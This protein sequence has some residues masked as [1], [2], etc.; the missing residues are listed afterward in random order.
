MDLKFD[1]VRIGKTRENYN[2]EIILKKNVDLLRKN[3]LDL[4]KEE[5]CSQKNNKEDITMIIPAR[6]HNIK[7]RL[8]DIKDYHIRKLL[9][10]NF[11][12]SIYKGN[13]DTIQDN[14]NNPVF[15]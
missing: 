2:S 15:R 6:G 13:L 11:P 9:R 8:Q 5:N 1:L 12:N 10:N 3:I 14:W 7:I 4:L